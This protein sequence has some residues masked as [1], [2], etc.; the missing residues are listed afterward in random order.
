ME[1]IL[2]RI[3]IATSFYGAPSPLLVVL[4]PGIFKIL[5]FFEIQSGFSANPFFF[6]PPLV[7]LLYY[8]SLLEILAL[9][10]FT[11]F[12][13]AST[14]YWRSIIFSS[15]S[16]FTFHMFIVF[17]RF[18]FYT[19]R[20]IRISGRISTHYLINRLCCYN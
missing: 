8:I 10:H 7:L 12:F 5:Q 2:S 19:S 3:S 6:L 11:F 4:H 1:T 17:R 20:F 9:G 18:Y 13:G 14:S 16:Y 15:S